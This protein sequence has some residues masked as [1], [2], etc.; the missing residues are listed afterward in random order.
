MV[1]VNILQGFAPPPSAKNQ[2]LGKKWVKN[3][4]NQPFLTEF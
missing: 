4:Q 2:Q 1:L 3:P